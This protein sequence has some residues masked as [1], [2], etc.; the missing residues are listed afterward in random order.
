MGGGTGT[1]WWTMGRGTQQGTHLSS[2]WPQHGLINVNSFIRTREDDPKQGCEPS[3]FKMCSG[4]TSSV[5]HFRSHQTLLLHCLRFPR[6][7]YSW[8]KWIRMW[9]LLSLCGRVL[10]VLGWR[11]PTP[12]HHALWNTCNPHVKDL[13]ADLMQCGPTYF[14]MVSDK[15]SLQI[16]SC[17]R[18]YLHF[19]IFVMLSSLWMEVIYIYIY[20]YYFVFISN[21]GCYPVLFMLFLIYYLIHQKHT[22]SESH[23]WKSTKYWIK[24][25]R[26][27][28]ISV[29]CVC[30]C[31]LLMD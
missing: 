11:S 31:M 22:H 19:H 13:Y 18:S 27:Q 5:S 2:S 3:V 20:I 12:R 23:E 7:R 17:V 26:G 6:S 21:K 1:I 10:I 28:H 15:I 4:S 30:V 24:G 14:L 25:L 8:P 29:V 16:Q 9:L